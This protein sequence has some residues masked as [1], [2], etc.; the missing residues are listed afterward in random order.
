MSADRTVSC[1]LRL[2]AIVTLI[3]GCITLLAPAQVVS[4]FDGFE[5]H[6]LHFVR[7]IGASLI[8]FSI[9]NWLYSYFHDLRAVLPAI[10]GN[11][12]SLV[13]AIIVD[14]LGLISGALSSATWLILGLHT[15]FAFT[16]WYCIRL[17]RHESVR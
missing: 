8:G 12:T 17:I 4:I 7:F 2:A 5:A 11:L 16:F 9:G 1:I 10:Y 6:N 15:I 13:L 3:I 14:V